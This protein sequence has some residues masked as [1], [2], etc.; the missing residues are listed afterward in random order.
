VGYT[1]NDFDMHHN[2][3]QSVALETQAITANGTVN[4]E[5]I[6]T[7]G[8]NSIEF[9]FI[10]STITDGAYAVKIQ[11]GDEVGGGD[12]ADVA[13]ELILGVADFADTDDNV[14]KRIGSLGKKRYQR[15]VV[16]GSGITAGGTLSAVAIQGA[17]WSAPVAD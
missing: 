17:P 5:I 10:S 12:M 14:A 16:T 15:A 7:Q 3:F 6:D 2:V 1:G 13:A 9:V 11:E 8:Y 4:G